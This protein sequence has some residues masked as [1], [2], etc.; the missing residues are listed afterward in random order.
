MLSYCITWLFTNVY[1]SFKKI[2]KQMA[3]FCDKSNFLMQISF[4]NL[5]SLLKVSTQC[6]YYNTALNVVHCYK[7]YSPL[8]LVGTKHHGFVTLVGPKS[9]HFGFQ[10]KLMGEGYD[11]L[12][13]HNRV[14]TGAKSLNLLSTSWNCSKEFELASLEA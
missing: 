3:L 11:V 4:S 10:Y 5:Q 9:K 6:T 8:Q 14:I 12:K 13:V 2:M 7:N 1:S